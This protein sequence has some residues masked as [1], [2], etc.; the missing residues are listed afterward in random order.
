MD[1]REHSDCPGIS[2][3]NSESQ[4]KKRPNDDQNRL[5]EYDHLKWSFVDK[6]LEL[7]GVSREFRWMIQSCLSSAHFS[8]LLNGSVCG[9]FKLERSIQQG[10]PLSPILFILCSEI[11]SRLLLKEEE[12]GRIYGIKVDRNASA[13]SHLMY[14]DDLIISCLANPGDTTFVMACL[15]YFCNWLGQLVNEEKSNI[16]F[17][18]STPQK[19]IKEIL[20]FKDMGA[21]ATYLGNSFVFGR[22]K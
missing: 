13:I 5:K 1:S 21:T 12:R 22:N 14:A 3:S 16:F 19:D 17:S 2:A 18:K 20:G 4:R 15:S 7:W 6:A 9:S 10:E 11:L 8:L